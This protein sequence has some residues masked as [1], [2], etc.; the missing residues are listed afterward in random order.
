MRAMRL[1]VLFDLPMGSRAERKS[2]AEFRKFL[3]KDGYH[4]EQFSVYSR[5]LFTRES[6]AA[7][8]ARLRMN[9]PT[10]GT[11]TV[12]EM[13]EKQYENRKVLL[14]KRPVVSETE[15]MQAQLTLVF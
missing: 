6:S 2:Y 3:I 9:L 15:S 4:M 12:I 8:I 11:V 13:T 5:I 7:H 10:A 1:L 14:S